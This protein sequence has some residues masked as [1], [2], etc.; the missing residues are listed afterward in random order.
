MDY[1]QATL[2]D[3]ATTAI[4]FKTIDSEFDFQDKKEIF[5]KGESHLHNKEQHLQGKYYENI[6][7]EILNYNQVLLF[8]PTDAKTELFNILMENH[9]FGTIRIKVKSSDKLTENQQ[10]AF[11]NNYFSE[12]K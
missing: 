9:R 11:I 12:L 6:G 5:Q 7:E 1:S 3:F 10:L 8:G 2:F 4:E